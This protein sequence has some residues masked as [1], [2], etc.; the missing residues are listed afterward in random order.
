MT[1]WRRRLQLG[2]AVLLAGLFV[3]SM[4]GHDV[5][6]HA[7]TPPTSPAAAQRAD[8][9]L[10]AAGHRL[11]IDGC[12]TCHGVDAGG[13]PGR[14]PSLRGVG[15]I[16]ADFY[17]RTHRMPMENP[18]DEPVRRPHSFYTDAQ[19]RQL[20]AYVGSYGGPRIPTVDPAAGDLARGK[21]L[22]T[23]NCAGC[24]QVQGEGGIVPG[25]F[26]PNLLHSKPIDVAEAVRV[27]PYIMPKFGFLT[28]SDVNDLARYVQ[29]TQ[30]PQ[31]RGGWGLGHIGPVPEGLVTFLL[32]MGA[33]LLGIR[34]I[35]ERNTE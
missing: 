3:V 29:Q 25:A 18:G 27:G 6:S 11:F 1:R 32:G 2:L 19:I 30:D 9:Q 35:G 4:G 20:V 7:Q 26:I 8:G 24:H 15:E 5:T 33:L 13:V 16:S 31:D 17:L 10:V 22:F 28:R 23:D 12:S 21:V 14:G 34:I